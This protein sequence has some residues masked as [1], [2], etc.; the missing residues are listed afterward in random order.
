M[1]GPTT[2]GATRC[3]SGLALALLLGLG[4]ACAHAPPMHCEQLTEVP[5]PE[6]L[7]VL[8][9]RGDSAVLVSSVERRSDE[10]EDGR[11]WVIH[12]DTGAAE[13]VP[14]LRRDEC[15]FHPHGLSTVERHD[16]RWEV[17]VVVHLRPEDATAPGCAVE[18]DD[19]EPPPPRLDAIERFEL[20]DDGLRFVERLSDPLMT[21]LNDVD[22]GPDGRL[23]VSN[24]PPWIEPKALVA[25]MI[26]GRRRGQV[27]L[28]RPVER[29]WS[30]A[31]RRM[32]YP[33][34]VAI[35]PSGG[36]LFVASAR[37]TVRHFALDGV[38]HSEGRPVRR[39]R[40]RGTLDNLVWGEDG[41]LWTTGHPSSLAFVRHVK[42]PSVIAPTE[43]FRVTPAGRRG[44]RLE[45]ERVLRIDDGNLDAGSVAQPVGGAL[46][47]GRVF[48][49]GV[50]VCR[51]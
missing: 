51:P 38:G 15:S 1:R 25:D 34:G 36:H 35:D 50:A 44:R 13:P 21:N 14:L 7:D 20:W 43:V 3:S 45:A 2:T 4:S 40:A 32:L 12:L 31:A 29:Q 16:G 37:G 28:W 24:N 5:G 27:L 47:I 11:L 42:D 41:S 23:W 22:A 19:L 30:V 6:D 17:Y 8:P 9:P 26:L 49:P 48:D 33:N 18:R 10:P 39:A 46:A